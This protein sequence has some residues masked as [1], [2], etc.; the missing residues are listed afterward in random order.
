MHKQS[1]PLS[2]VD[3]ANSTT[4]IL[5]DSQQKFQTIDGFGFT[6]TGGSALLI[7][8]MPLKQR[9]AL[10]QELFGKTA[11]AISISYLRISVGASDLSESVF[12]Y[13]DLVVGETDTLLQQFNLSK[14]TI[15]LIPLIKQIVAINPS[16]KFMATPWSPPTWMKTNNN[17]MGGSLIPQ[18]Y[19]AYARYLVKYIQAM[20]ANGISIDALTIQNEPQHGGNN[21]SMLMT[22]A[23][24][25]AFI[26]DHLG[27]MF[28]KLAINTKIIIW[29]HNCDH[30]EFPIHILNDPAA[31]RYIDGSAFHLYAGDISALSAV[32]KAHPNKNIY[33]T[34]QW[35][36]S[37]GSFDGDLKWHV[38]NV[39]VGSARNHAKAIIEWNLASDPNYDPHT[40][41]GC[42]ECK[43]AITA[44]TTNYT[45]NV[46]YYIIAHASKFVPMGSVRIGSTDAGGI[47]TAAFVRP[48]GKKVL[49]AVNDNASTT[50]FVIKYKGSTVQASL[51]KG[52]VGT[53]VWN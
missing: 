23:E 3:Y 53:Y 13:N 42:S 27:P 26:K 21:P 45:R 24:Q 38:K 25:A 1:L 48:D 50:T 29:D 40:P 8:Q 41:G 20:K 31:N 35:T 19:R 37:K 14:D 18:Y 10:L 22:A 36:G 2:K 7:Q 17:S 6:L 39:L 16:M 15:H 32:K 9:N 28:A 5:I 52:A 11:D 43:G 30:P 44:T 49:V 12:S 4:R 33:F 46:S 34:E 51:T 47:Y